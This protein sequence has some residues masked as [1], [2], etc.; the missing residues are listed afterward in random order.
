MRFCTDLPVRD[1]QE[2]GDRTLIVS[3]DGKGQDISQ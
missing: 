3:V 1:L 2:M